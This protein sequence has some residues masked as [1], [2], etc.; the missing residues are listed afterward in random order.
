[1]KKLIL[2]SN[3]PRRKLLLEQMNIPFTVFS[4]KVKVNEDYDETLS[5]TEIVQVLAKRKAKAVLAE[6]SDAVVLGSD[7]I[8][9]LNGQVLGKPKDKEEAKEMLS[10]LSGRTHSVLT[11][12]AIVSADKEVIFAIETF[13]EFYKLSDE[14]IDYYV[15]T[16][17]P[18]DKAGAYGIQGIGAF[19]VK[20]IEGDFFSVVGLPIAR[21][22]RELASF[23]ITPATS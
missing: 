5:A 14:E 12:V 17:E 2:A 7:T 10:M 19:L 18:L 20:K 6:H 23:G 1:M 3:S 13:V 22:V 8:V 11:G 15:S 21:T 4:S 9:V 16:N